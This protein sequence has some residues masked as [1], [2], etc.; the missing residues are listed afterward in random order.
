MR[1]AHLLDEGL[2]FFWCRQG[3]VCSRDN[4][5]TSLAASRSQRFK[6]TPHVDSQD[7]KQAPLTPRSQRQLHTP[8]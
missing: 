2:R 6:I 4:G 8:A 5:Y 7:R 3:V 1:K